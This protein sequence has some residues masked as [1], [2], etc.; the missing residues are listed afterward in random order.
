M[1][2]FC[3]A[4]IRRNPGHC[5]FLLHQ[6]QARLLHFASCIKHNLVYC[7]LPPALCAIPVAAAL[8]YIPKNPADSNFPA[9]IENLLQQRSKQPKHRLHCKYKDI[10]FSAEFLCNLL[11]FCDRIQRVLFQLHHR[12]RPV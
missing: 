6:T 1:N 8:C 10:P 2:Q 7:T 9:S 4:F 11:G 5:I 12:L 3:F